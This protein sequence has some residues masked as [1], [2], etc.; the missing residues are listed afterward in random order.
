MASFGL[1][2]KTKIPP[3]E[4]LLKPLWPHPKFLFGPGPSNPNARI[5]NASSLPMLGHFQTE[6]HHILDEIQAGLRYAFQTT[7]TYT[8]VFTGAGHTGMEG[9]MMNIVEREQK[10]LICLNGM[11][12]MRAKNIAERQGL[13]VRVIEKPA[14]EAF[15]LEDIKKGLEE[16]KPVAMFITHS[17]SSTGVCQPLE[18]VGAL[19]HKY[20]CLVIADT[21]ASLGGTPFF[22]DDLE[23]DVVYTGSQKVFACP[24]GICPITFSPKAIERVKNRKTP[25]PS[26]YL[27]ILELGNYWGC[28]GQP[29]RYHHTAPI[30]LLYTLRESLAMLVEE[31]LENCWK[32]HHDNIEIF[33]AGIEKMGLEMFVKDKNLRLP[34]VTTIKIPEGYP[35]WKAVGS[36]LMEKYHFE[37]VGGMGPTVGLVWRIGLMGLNSRKENI[38]SVLRLFEEAFNHVKA[39]K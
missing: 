17:E 37:I 20:D 15:T 2:K 23:L 16:H 33:W 19:C 24:P 5:Y 39:E 29:R 7:N 25:V 35:D 38:P 21:V 1:E 3:P 34:T 22:T 27:D 11:W 4:Q 9:A 32:R 12:G 31:G 8:I 10:I 26:F 13:D 6:F 14:G 36:Y 30:N 28:D 18:G